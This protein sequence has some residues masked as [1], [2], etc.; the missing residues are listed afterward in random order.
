M[1]KWYISEDG[2]VSGPFNIS[3]IKKSISKDKDLYG[4]N[5]SFKH[6]LPVSQIDEFKDFLPQTTKSNQISEALIEKFIST[7]RDLSK[8]LSLIDDSIESTVKSMNSFDDKITYYKELTSDLAPEV[9]DN[10]F[11][12][13]KKYNSLNKQLDDL[14][15]AAVVVKKEISDTVVEFDELVL[16]T[17][18]KNVKVSPELEPASSPKA[19]DNVKPD[20]I[21]DV[22]EVNV[23]ENVKAIKPKSEKVKVTKSIDEVIEEPASVVKPINN[24]VEDI[25]KEPVLKT[26][27]STSVPRNVTNDSVIRNIT[28]QNHVNETGVN[29]RKNSPNSNL[30]LGIKP[31][32]TAHPFDQRQQVNDKKKMELLNKDKSRAE[33]SIDETEKSSFSDVKSKFKSV[34]GQQ[35]PEKDDSD[36]ISDELKKLEKDVIDEG[37]EDDEFVFIDPED[38]VEA[39]SAKKRRRKRRF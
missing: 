7:K 26:K 33:L 2:K 23:A 36:K 20:V 18:N 12:L 25:A 35:K 4:W 28:P 9:K 32:V 3:D 30:D 21:D 8:K 13:E 22:K 14:E 5:P 19:L 1:K 15:K 17:T 11:P 27:R 34:F 10:I 31:F 37:N 38:R 29:R 24:V 39:D 6:W 16:D